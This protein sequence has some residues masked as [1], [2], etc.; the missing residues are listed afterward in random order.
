MQ[1][2]Q[3]SKIDSEVNDLIKNFKSKLKIKE[4]KEPS[5]RSVKESESS[6]PVVEK[7]GED[8]ID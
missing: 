5:S 3:E 8:S 6:Q 7:V 4:E 1:S 2:L